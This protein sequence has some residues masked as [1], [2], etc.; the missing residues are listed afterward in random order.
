MKNNKLIAIMV[1]LL[2]L[3]TA[4]AVWYTYRAYKL[5]NR[6]VDVTTRI[7]AAANMRSLAT[8]TYNDAVIYSKTHPDIVP[9]L[10]A[11]TNYAVQATSPN[12]K[13]PGK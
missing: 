8:A 12:L 3:C 13:N 5:Q 10:Q 6:L 11:V 7:N 1:A 9:I 2:F 4:L